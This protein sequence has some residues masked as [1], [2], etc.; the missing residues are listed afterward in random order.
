[1]SQATR[2]YREQCTLH[3][4]EPTPEQIIYRANILLATS[5]AEAQ[6][7]PQLRQQHAEVP[8]PMRPGVR[9]ALMKLDSRSLAG[10]PR[11]AFRDGALPTTFVGSPDTVVKQVE[12]CRWRDQFL[13]IHGAMSALAWSQ[14][15]LAKRDRRLE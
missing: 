12:R 2:Y 6:E 10:I 8:F 5:D 4:W 7:A 11:P 9:N 14:Q 3:G 1:M 15:P 13:A